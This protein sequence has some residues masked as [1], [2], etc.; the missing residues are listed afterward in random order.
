MY[1]NWG[2]TGAELK[3]LPPA[4]VRG[5]RE[6]NRGGFGSDLPY[7]LGRVLM[8]NTYNSELYLPLLDEYL[9]RTESWN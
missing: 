3:T 9:K 6:N 5:F 2:I 1:R 8:R 7:D 4:L